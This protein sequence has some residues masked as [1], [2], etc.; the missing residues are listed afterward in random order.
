MKHITI[1]LSL[2]F[3]SLN[4]DAEEINCPSE[5]CSPDISTQK[6]S[7]LHI[8]DLNAEL[9]KIRDNGSDSDRWYYF[10]LFSSAV[11]SDDLTVSIIKNIG[12]NMRLD[13]KKG[14]LTIEKNGLKQIFQIGA[15]SSSNNVCPNYNLEILDASEKHAVIRKK[16]PLF[17]Y[18]KNESYRG[19]DYFLYDM[20]TASM[21][22]FWSGY[23][24]NKVE[25]FPEASPIP[26]SNLKITETGYEFKWTGSSKSSLK[27]EIFSIDAKYIRERNKK[28]K[29]LEMR[30]INPE[31]PKGEF[32]GGPCEKPG[33]PTILD[34]RSH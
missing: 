2:L 16:C 8:P 20:E 18:G 21:F 30:C 33:A 7:V 32:T 17:E 1:L 29:K 3:F 22:S 31:D 5:H 34:Q 23:S 28:T 27:K 24:D 25:K 10:K 4:I 14:Y 26:T 6:P 12:L 9:K 15:P 19:T 13:P 11:S